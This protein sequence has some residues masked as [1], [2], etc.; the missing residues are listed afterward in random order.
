MTKHQPVMLEEVINCLKV[1]KG[2]WYLDTT[3]GGG[4]HSLA[5]LK[6]GGNLI[7]LDWDKENIEI[8][9]KHLVTACPSGVSYHLYHLNYCQLDEA[10]DK[11]QVKSL[12]GILFDLGFST[13]QLYKRR[14]FSF[15]YPSEV[16][17][18]RYNSQ[19][20]Q[21]AWQLLRNLGREEIQRSLEVYS[22]QPRAAEIALKLCHLARE[23]K[24][25]V[26][27]VIKVV[28]EVG[29]KNQ[30][31]KIHPATKVIQAL[32]I[33]VNQ[34]LDNLRCG[35]VKAADSLKEGGRLVVISFHSGE[36]RI[37]KEFIRRRQDLVSITKKAKRPIKEE[38][39][40]NPRSRSARLRVAE[41]KGE[42]ND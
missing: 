25:T 4:G 16:L 28:E 35:L 17:D 40:E 3:F 27:D 11:S 22:Q 42:G 37:V 7:A 15:H 19:T 36:D 5:I 21:P 23:K 26:G 34:E 30:P 12:R 14:G 41:K 24:I 10:L 9:R 38:I 2:E 13:D 33:L 8:G 29:F 1:E 32:R 6:A 18:L 31:K 39:A 20:G